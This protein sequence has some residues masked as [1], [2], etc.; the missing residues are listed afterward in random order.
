[1]DGAPGAGFV[2][3][4]PTSL[5][6]HGHPVLVMGRSFGLG[7]VVSHPCDNNKDVAWMGHPAPVSWS[8]FPRL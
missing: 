3:L 5:T 7:F 6:R 8:C 4:F 1:M 2:E